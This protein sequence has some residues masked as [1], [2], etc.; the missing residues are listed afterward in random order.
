MSGWRALRMA[1]V[2]RHEGGRRAGEGLQADPSGAQ[3]GDRGDLLLGGVESGEDAD[4]VAGEHLPGLGEA[5]LA[6][7]A[8]DEDGPGALLEATDHLRDGRLGEAQRVGGARE[9][10]LVGDGLH[11]PQAG[12]IDHDAIITDDYGKR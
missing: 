7:V 12:S 10:S 4:G 9:A 6:P 3:A 8:L 11:D 2:S 1:S 5:D